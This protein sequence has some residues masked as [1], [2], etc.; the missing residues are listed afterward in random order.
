MTFEKEKRKNEGR[1][2][3]PWWLLLVGFALGVA[4]TLAV[5]QARSQPVSGNM[6]YSEGSQLTATHLIEGATGTAR[7]FGAYDPLYATASAMA[8]PNDGTPGS[9]ELD[10][11]IVTATHIVEQ[12]TL[13]SSETAAATTP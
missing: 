13:Q 3:F 1:R 7:A 8:T 12:A 10:P 9:A 5:A 2:G 4:A 11:L 6:A